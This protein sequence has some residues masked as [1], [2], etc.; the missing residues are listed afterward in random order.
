M[1]LL[2]LLTQATGALQPNS[3]GA[4]PK[5]RPF[6]WRRIV[7]LTTS[8]VAASLPGH[9]AGLIFSLVPPSSPVS[10]GAETRVE[11]LAVNPTPVELPFETAKTLPGQ[12]SAG[13]KTWSVDL[14]RDHLGPVV[15]QAGAFAARSYHFTLPPDARGRVV[16]TFEITAAFP[17]RTVIDVGAAEGGGGQGTSESITAL[18]G[19]NLASDAMINRAFAGRFSPNEPVYFI[20]GSGKHAAAKF[21][22]SFNYRLGTIQWADDSTSR[23]QLGYTQRSLWDIR[24]RSSPF[25]DTSYMPEL[26]IDKMASLPQ[27][28]DRFFTYIGTMGGLKHESNGRDG[29]D[30]R[31]LNTIY[32]RT[33][34][35]FGSLDSW[36]L[37]LAPEVF[38]YVSDLGDNENIKDYRGYGRFRAVF[39]KTNGPSLL[40]TMWAGRDFDHLTYQLDLSYPL[41]THFMKIESFL[42]LQYFN[43]YGESIK[44]YDRK[45]DALRF[46]IEVVR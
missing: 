36:H 19:G 41:R 31:S 26:S 29:I 14:E 12:L 35:A 7:S 44:D 24:G 43:G 1:N 21:Q 27:K 8:L 13:E 9:A 30:S 45:S 28:S 42:L 20:Y 46:G 22:F 34:L 16:M 17:L 38:G 32:L 23:I 39:G 10:P 18:G 40:A 33:G 25:Y 11:V 5:S 15:V 3:F 6:R 4:V 37:I 2:H